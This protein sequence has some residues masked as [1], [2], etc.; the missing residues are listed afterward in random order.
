VFIAMLVW[1]GNKGVA[2]S[3]RRTLAS[4]YL[5]TFQN[6]FNLTSLNQI[7]L[8]CVSIYLSMEY[9]SWCSSGYEFNREVLKWENKYLGLQF[10]FSSLRIIQTLKILLSVSVLLEDKYKV[11]DEQ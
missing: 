5:S 7:G 11:T 1:H 8:I 10:N 6:H 2:F 4:N 9:D 3:G